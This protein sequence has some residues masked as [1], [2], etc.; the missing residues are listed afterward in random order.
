MQTKLIRLFVS[1]TFSDFTEEREI[2]N[3]EVFPHIAAYCK[4][5]GF[6]FQ[7]VDLRYGITA[8]AGENNSTMDICLEEVARCQRTG[9]Y[10]NFMLLVGNRCGWT[11]V[12]SRIKKA[13]Y[14]RILEIY[15]SYEENAP[16]IQYLNYWYHLDENELPASYVLSPEKPGWAFDE[17][18]L[19]SIFS[20]MMKMGLFTEEEKETYFF[21]A[22]G[23]EILNGLLKVNDKTALSHIICISRDLKPLHGL[24]SYVDL[25]PYKKSNL[26]HLKEKIEKTC[27][28]K[29]VGYVKNYE[30]SDTSEWTD[31]LADFREYITESLLAIVNKSIDEYNSTHT[32]SEKEIHSEYLESHIDNIEG[33]EDMAKVCE[34][35]LAAPNQNAL[36]FYGK[37]GS[38]KTSLMLAAIKRVIDLPKFSAI[39][40]FVG[41]SPASSESFGLISNLTDEICDT[42][43]I[44]KPDYHS[45]SESI[46][47]FYDVLKQI[48]KEENLVICIDAV[49]QLISFTNENE[50]LWLSYELPENVWMIVT[51]RDG[52]HHERLIGTA[53]FVKSVSIPALSE[54]YVPA[55]TKRILESHGRTLTEEQYDLV[56]EAY[57]KE[58]LPIY[59]KIIAS[60]LTTWASSKP[61]ASCKNELSPDMKEELLDFLR[62]LR[63]DA[64]HGE[65]L[66]DFTFG[67]MLAARFGI[68][69]Q[70]LLYLLSANEKVRADY[71]RL[72]P[73]SP[74]LEDNKP[75]PFMLWSRLYY[76]VSEFIKTIIYRGNE[77]IDFY[78]LGI[79]DLI[80]ADLKQGY[81]VIHHCRKDM[82]SYY[83]NQPDFYDDNEQIIN[84]RKMSE[85]GFQYQMLGE[86]ESLAALL[87]RPTYAK[88]KLMLGDLHEL[89]SE[90]FFAASNDF[91]AP[92]TGTA[93]DGNTT[94]SSMTASQSREMFRTVF[95][96]LLRF[97]CRDHFSHAYLEDVHNL[98]IFK[99][100]HS[101]H[102]RFFELADEK[103]FVYS[104]LSSEELPPSMN[105]KEETRRILLQCQLKN[106]N[107][108]RRYGDLSGAI[109][110]AEEAEALLQEIIS[111][112][113]RDADYQEYARLMYDI[114]YVYFYNE[115]PEK[116]FEAMRKSIENAKHI[117]NE[118]S[119]AMSET[120]YHH[121][122]FY[123]AVGTP[124][125]KEVLEAQLR[126]LDE[127]D[128]IFLLNSSSNLSA[129]RW[130]INAFSHRL[131]TNFILG[132]DEA[133]ISSYRKFVGSQTEIY[134]P[135]TSEKVEAV[136]MGACGNYADAISLM[137][138][139]IQKLEMESEP[140]D[141]DF[142][143]LNYY[144][145]Q[146]LY[147]RSGNVE[148][149]AEIK[150]HI[151]EM[152]R[153]RG[154]WCF[155]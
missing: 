154:N 72:Y 5:H 20:E 75:L 46:G 31:Y 41:I 83:E 112:N 19:Y 71:A 62:F 67:F 66:V 65:N 79:R 131:V 137:E 110:A 22:T 4:K 24:D 82:V 101:V 14:E 126:Y 51:T 94:P 109:H 129:K 102:Q 114:A 138:K 141:I 118:L 153:S 36:C 155:R 29:E 53:P 28:E 135:S 80:E 45:Y 3:R 104:I 13:D 100:D 134:N 16:K 106:L 119:A 133:V 1:S 52:K 47:K 43:A 113:T 49:D 143:T 27:T 35:Y 96:E 123:E 130:M 150:A 42:Y 63:S 99:K 40:R 30:L 48:P 86:K 152:P 85:L 68:T 81:D 148:K 140:K 57:K 59:L 7:P 54:T 44:P 92:M 149:A 25:E 111:D 70:D 122:K 125:E 2:L 144:I 145:L 107:R 17:S 98:F 115:E 91:E 132:N 95:T 120:E 105:A 64:R 117:H 11:P 88:A 97:M 139:T 84:E 74:R 50:L 12:P 78:H 18:I 61:A 10:P 69:E 136:Y 90:V 38:G 37:R 33:R 127:A 142:H 56:R 23:Q 73:Q 124:S 151:K 15:S 87:S 121:L 116:A 146:L 128:R 8:A 89:L 34:D 76:D 39:Y 93:A 6:T 108:T 26:K 55:I 60:K 9:H 103:D 58:M 32:G 147:S 21:S 77:M